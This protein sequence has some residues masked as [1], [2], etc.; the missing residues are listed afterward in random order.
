MEQV[1]AG[2]AS[3]VMKVILP[4]W[5]HWPPEACGAKPLPVN[6]WIAGSI[7]RIRPLPP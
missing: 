1:T 5:L 3:K 7:A 4:R 6:V 2:I